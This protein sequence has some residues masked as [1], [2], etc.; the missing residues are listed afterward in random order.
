VTYKEN[1]M[2][3]IITDDMDVVYY[4]IKVNGVAVSTTFAEKLVA[5]M[6]KNNLPEEQ[7]LLAEVVPVTSDGKQVLLG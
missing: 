6:A 4:V 1:K 3:N 5:E 2:N 7:R